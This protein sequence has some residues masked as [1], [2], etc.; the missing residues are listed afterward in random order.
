M[1]VVEPVVGGFSFENCRRNAILQEKGLKPPNAY[2]TGTTIVG[3]V[4]KDGIVLG[5]DTRA[6]ED[7]VVADKNCSKIHYIADN[8]YCCGAG[9]AADTEMTT[10]MISSQLQLHKLNTGRVPRVCVA[11][12]LLKQML[13]RYQGHI[14]AALVLGGVDNTGPHL[15]SVYPHGSTD[16]LPYVTMGSGSLAAMSV[17]EDGYKPDMEMEDAMK[18]VRDAI[19][20]GIFNDLGSGSNVDLCVI[21]KDLKVDYLRPYDEANQK[22]IRQGKYT[23]KRGTTGVLTSEVKKLPVLVTS[24]KV[25]STESSMDT[26]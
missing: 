17:F 7:T 14:S 2:K 11:N 21:K 16:K 10:Q 6:T 23:Y 25:K 26:S 15:Y 3:V 24:S 8:I 4:F 13:F 19:A 22:G 12:R 5:A 1:A 9:T 18:L 20:A